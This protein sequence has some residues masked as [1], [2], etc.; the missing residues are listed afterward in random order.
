VIDRLPPLAIDDLHR[1]GDALVE[2]LLEMSPA[3]SAAIEL[4]Q[5]PADEAPGN[6]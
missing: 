1:A 4:L 2:A 5:P 6:A 3:S